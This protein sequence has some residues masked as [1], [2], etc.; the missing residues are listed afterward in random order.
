MSVSN[1]VTPVNNPEDG[2]V[3]TN[4][5]LPGNQSAEVCLTGLDTIQFHSNKSLHDQ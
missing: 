1:H 2:R 4:V 5:S 3:N